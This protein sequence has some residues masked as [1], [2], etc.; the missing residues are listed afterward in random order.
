[1]EMCAFIG[2]SHEFFMNLKKAGFTDDLIQKVINSRNNALAE[3][4]YASVVETATKNS[5]AEDDFDKL[6]EFEIT[7]SGNFDF[8][9]FRFENEKLFYYFEPALVGKNFK[10]NVPLEVVKKKIVEIYQLKRKKTREECLNFIV[11]QNGQLPNAHGLAIVWQ[12][13][14]EK[15]PQGIWIVGFDQKENI[16]RDSDGHHRVP[17]LIQN[18][19]GD[20]DF[21]LGR[22][23]DDW[24]SGDC[25]LFFRDC[26]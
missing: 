9:A 3:K 7:I 19:D 25:V 13:A 14:K 2:K 10:S 24:H 8:D 1:M 22:F 21:F 18:S 16:F 17:L 6:K 5:S 12:Q 11:S 23:E 15:L 26:A 20:W 4:M